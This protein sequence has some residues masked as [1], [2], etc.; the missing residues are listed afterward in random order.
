MPKATKHGG[1]SGHDGGAQVADLNDELREQRD[2][3]PWAVVSN[4]GRGEV[5][6]EAL[7]AVDRGE[8][9]DLGDFSQYLSDDDAPPPKRK[10]GR[11]RK[12]AGP[13]AETASGDAE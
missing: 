3:G 1:P 6:G 12:V 5:I 4:A 9:V 13:D 10:P 8:S 11:P 7:D 2:W